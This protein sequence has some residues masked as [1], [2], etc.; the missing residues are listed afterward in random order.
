MSQ[1][2]FKALEY[3]E[4]QIEGI[5]PKSDISHTFVAHNRANGLLP[6][7]EQRRSSNRYFELELESLPEDDGAA[8]LS[9]RRRALVVCRVRYDIPNDLAYRRRMMAEDAEYI[10]TK[11]KGPDYSLSTTG[12][13]S[14]IPEPP[15]VDPVEIDN[16]IA[17]ILSIPFTLLYLEA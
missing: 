11:L 17:H 5:T 7:L 12:I 3:L 15:L 9:G 4:D 1:G 6:P 8:G 16:T 2:I 10:L 14:V 13:V